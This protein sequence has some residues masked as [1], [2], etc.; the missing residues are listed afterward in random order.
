[1]RS[2]VILCLLI[3]SFHGEAQLLGVSAELVGKDSYFISFDNDTIYGDVQYA[4]SLFSNR[5]RKIYFI[6]GD[7]FRYTLRAKHANGFMMT[8]KF[9][10]SRL[11]DE[12]YYFLRP[13][14]TG[15]PALYVLEKNYMRRERNSLAMMRA[16][17]KGSKVIDQYIETNGKLH[18]LYAR[19]FK[20][21]APRLFEDYPV[22]ID[23]IQS[24]EYSYSDIEE[25]VLF[26]NYSEDGLGEK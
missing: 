14:I 21:Q 15:K 6:D 20:K 5:L 23:M 24:G 13:A 16:D 2:I 8:G 9:Y 17:E 7:G 3:T 12:M 11:V 26:C 19:R 22:V 4:K 18:K 10:V 1:M 25:I